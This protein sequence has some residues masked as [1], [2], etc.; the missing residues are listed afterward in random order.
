MPERF[1]E[2][3][4]KERRG[5]RVRCVI[6]TD[7]HKSE[8]AR[9]L[10]ELVFPHAVV[11]PDRHVWQPRG[12][13]DFSEAKLGETPKFLSEQ[14]RETLTNWW[15]A[16][17]SRANTPNWDVVSQATMEGRDGLILV[18]AKA[19]DQ[20]LLKEIVG[21]SDTRSSS[22][23]SRANH[24]RIGKAILEAN[25]ALDRILPGWN[26]SRDSHYQLSNRFAWAWKVASLGTPIVLV[27]LG[28]LQAEEMRDQGEPFRDVRA[29]EETVRAHAKGIVPETAWDQPLYLN[30][31]PFRALIRAVRCDLTDHFSL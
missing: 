3:K 1:G 20:E 27:Y 29:W 31:I 13:V 24:E 23:N 6:F 21:K 16:V 10:T 14:D 19:H 2:L 26:L 17:R 11:Y 5:S 8:V 4:P 22:D 12:F 15:L 9:R 25:D 30:G 28:F 7:G 18:E